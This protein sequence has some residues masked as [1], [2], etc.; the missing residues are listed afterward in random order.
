M[1]G[2]F[3]SCEICSVSVGRVLKEFRA[4]LETL[5]GRSRHHPNSCQTRGM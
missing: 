5:H 2:L 4:S 1:N 3:M